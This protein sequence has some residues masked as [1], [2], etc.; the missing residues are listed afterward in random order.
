MAIIS[1]EVPN[2]IAKTFSPYM[3]V[4]S[5]EL[6]EKLEENKVDLISFWKKWI[7]KNEFE[8]YLSIKDSI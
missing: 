4:S 5:Y 3:I 6:Y 8:E 1:V 2:E 7:W